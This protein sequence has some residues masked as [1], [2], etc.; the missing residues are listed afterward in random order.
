MVYMVYGIQKLAPL[1]HAL[2]RGGCG[3]RQHWCWVDISASAA[4]NLATR[5]VEL[6]WTDSSNSQSQGTLLSQLSQTSPFTN[7]CCCRG[8]IP[9]FLQIFFA[10]TTNFTAQLHNTRNLIYYHTSQFRENKWMTCIHSWFVSRNRPF[11]IDMCS[12][13]LFIYLFSFS[14]FLFFK[15]STTC[16]SYIK[17]IDCMLNRDC[18][19]FQLCSCIILVI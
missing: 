10:T 14:F 3:D 1:L 9:L 6:F 17:L 18:D 5:P 11:P 12:Y 7:S 8:H 4:L 19:R 15:T 2:R 16:R 13:C